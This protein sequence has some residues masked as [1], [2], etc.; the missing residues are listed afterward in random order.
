MLNAVARA[1]EYEHN[2][3]FVVGADGYARREIEAFAG[4]YSHRGGNAGVKVEPRR[5]AG[6]GGGNLRFLAEFFKGQG[7]V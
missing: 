7:Y 6:G 5:K 4:V 3:V 2:Y 1:H